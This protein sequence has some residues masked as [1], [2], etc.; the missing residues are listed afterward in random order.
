MPGL[1]Y[2][3]LNSRAIFSTVKM[4]VDLLMES[5]NRM[6]NVV[7]RFGWSFEDRTAGPCIWFHLADLGECP[8]LL[9]IAFKSLQEFNEKVGIIVTV[10]CLKAYALVR[11]ALPSRVIVLLMPL[12]NPVSAALFMRKWRPQVGIFMEAPFDTNLVLIAAQYNVRL[13]LL[14]AHIGPQDFLQWHS[15]RSSRKLLSN[16]LQCFSLV[17]PQSDLDM[18]YLRMFGASM[19]QMPGWS[20]ALS[21]VA[22]LGSNLWNHEVPAK[23]IL[24]QRKCLKG[25]KAW[26]AVNIDAGEEDILIR[27]HK[28]LCSQGQH[29]NLLTVIAP[30]DSHRCFELS[31]T[32]RRAGLSVEL[33]NATDVLLLD[34]PAQLGLFYH[35]CELVYYGGSMPSSCSPTAKSLS[36]MASAAVASCALLVGSTVATEELG[37]LICG[38]NGAAIHA[39]ED[40]AAAVQ[41][42]GQSLENSSAQPFSHVAGTNARAGVTGQQSDSS[43]HKS[44]NE[45]H[46]PVNHALQQAWEYCTW[47]NHGSRPSSAPN[48][49]ITAPW[50]ANSSTTTTPERT[51]MTSVGSVIDPYGVWSNSLSEDRGSRMCSLED[52]SPG[53]ASEARRP[54]TDLSEL[55]N[56]LSS[57]AGTQTSIADRVDEDYAVLHAQDSPDQSVCDSAYC[58]M[59]DA[60]ANVVTTWK[61]ETRESFGGWVVG[62]DNRLRNLRVSPAKRVDFC[63]F[64][65]SEGTQSNSL[66]SLSRGLST[67]LVAPQGTHSPPQGTSTTSTPGHTATFLVGS[68]GRVVCP[69]PAKSPSRFARSDSSGVNSPSRSAPAPAPGSEL[70]APVVASTQPP[71][72]AQ[73]QAELPRKNSPDAGSRKTP[74]APLLA[75]SDDDPTAH[76][77]E[78]PK[79]PDPAMETREIEAMQHGAEVSPPSQQIS[80]RTSSNDMDACEQTDHVIGSL[81]HYTLASSL[82]R[83]RPPGLPAKLP[84]AGKLTTAAPKPEPKADC[85]AVSSITLSPRRPVFANQDLARPALQDSPLVTEKPSWMC[86]N[87]NGDLQSGSSS[88]SPVSPDMDMGGSP[89]D[90]EPLPPGAGLISPCEQ[91]EHPV[92]TTMAQ[93]ATGPNLV[94][95]A[96]SPGGKNNTIDI[97]PRECTL[98]NFV[99]EGEELEERRNSS[100]APPS[101]TRSRDAQSWS[102]AMPCESLLPIATS[103]SS[104]LPGMSLS[105]DSSLKCEPISRQAIAPDSQLSHLSRMSSMDRGHYYDSAG[106]L[107][108]PETPR[109]GMVSMSPMA[110]NPEFDRPC[111][112]SNSPR[113]LVVETRALRRSLSHHAG[114]QAQPRHAAP[115]FS[116]HASPAR[117]QPVFSGGS[118]LGLNSALQQVEDVPETPRSCM[119][120]NSLFAVDTVFDRPCLSPDQTRSNPAKS[121]VPTRGWLPPASPRKDVDS[122][123]RWQLEQ[124]A[125]AATDRL[126][127]PNRYAL[128]PSPQKLKCVAPAPKPADSLGLL[129][130]LAPIATSPAHKRNTSQALRPVPNGSNKAS[131][132]DNSIPETSNIALM[133]LQQAEQKM[134]P[135]PVLKIRTLRPSPSVIPGDSPQISPLPVAPPIFPATLHHSPG[136]LDAPP[137]SPRRLIVSMS[138]PINTWE[139]ASGVCPDPVQQP[140]KTRFSFDLDTL[141][142]NGNTVTKSLSGP[143]YMAQVPSNLQTPSQPGSDQAPVQPRPYQMRPEKSGH[144]EIGTAMPPFPHRLSSRKSVSWGA[145]SFEHASSPSPCSQRA[146]SSHELR[147]TPSCNL[148]ARSDTGSDRGHSAD[149]SA[150]SPRRRANS[151]GNQ[152]QECNN[153]HRCPPFTQADSREI[154]A[155]VPKSPRRLSAAEHAATTDASSFGYASSQGSVV[156]RPQWSSADSGSL[157]RNRENATS[158]PKS[159]RRLSAAEHAA[160]TDASSFGYASREGSVVSR[161]QWTSVDGGSPGRNRENATSV[162]KSPRC[163]SAAEQAATTDASSFGYVSMEG[164]VVSRPQWTLV[165]GGSPGRCRE[166]A[167]TVPKS[168][169]RLSAAE[170]AATTDASSFKS[171][172][173]EGSVVSRVQWTPVEGGSTGRCVE[174]ATTVPKS[175]RRLSAAE[176]AATT[177]VSSFGSVSREG[178]VVSRVQWTPVDGGSPGKCVE[179]A[180]T[181]PKSPRRLSAFKHA[182]TTDASSF[183]SVSREGSVVSRLQWTS[184][185][186]GSPG[187]CLENATTVPK[188][189]RH[190]SA[191]ENA[192]T[193]DASSFG[194]VSREGSVVSR[195]QMTSVDGGS[196]GRSGPGEVQPLSPRRLSMDHIYSTLNPL[197]QSKNAQATPATFHSPHKEPTHLLP[198]PLMNPDAPQR[199]LQ[200]ILGSASGSSRLSPGGQS[201]T[202]SSTGSPIRRPTTA[203]ADGQSNAKPASLLKRNSSVQ[204]RRSSGSSNEGPVLVPLGKEADGNPTDTGALTGRREQVSQKDPQTLSEFVRHGLM[205]AAQE[206]QNGSKSAKMNSPPASQNS[207]SQPPPS[208]RKGGGISQPPVPQ[209]ISLPAKGAEDS[210]SPSS[211]PQS[212]ISLSNA[213]R[214]KNV[215]SPSKGPHRKLFGADSKNPAPVSAGPARL[216]DYPMPFVTKE[217]ALKPLFSVSAPAGAGTKVS[218]AASAGSST[219]DTLNLMSIQGAA[220]IPGL[221]RVPSPADALISCMSPALVVSSTKPAGEDDDETP[222]S[223]PKASAKTSLFSPSPQKVVAYPLAKA[224]EMEQLQG[225]LQKQVRPAA[226]AYDQQKQL[227]Q[228]GSA[229]AQAPASN[230]G[231][232]VPNSALMLLE[233]TM[234]PV[235]ALGATAAFNPIKTAVSGGLSDTKRMLLAMSTTTRVPPPAPAAPDPLT[236][237]LSTLPLVR[238]KKAHA[239]EVRVAPG[240]AAVRSVTN[241]GGP[242]AVPATASAAYT[243]AR[244]AA[245]P[246]QQA[247]VSAGY[248]SYAEL[249]SM[250]SPCPSAQGGIP[251]GPEHVAAGAVQNTL[252]LLKMPLF[253][254]HGSAH[255]QGGRKLQSLE[256]KMSSSVQSLSSDTKL[257]MASIHQELQNMKEEMKALMQTVISRPP[258]IYYVQS[259]ASWPAPTQATD[260][261]TLPD[262]ITP[263]S[264]F[265][266]S[267]PPPS[268]FDP[269]STSLNHSH[270][271]PQSHAPHRSQSHAPHGPQPHSSAESSPLA[272]EREASLTMFRSNPIPMPL[273][274]ESLSMAKSDPTP[275]IQRD[276]SFDLASP[277][278]TQPL[279]VPFYTSKET[280]GSLSYLLGASEPRKGKTEKPRQAS[281]RTAPP[282][283]NA[284]MESE[285]LP[286][287][288]VRDPSSSQ[289]LHSP[290]GGSSDSPKTDGEDGP[291][292]SSPWPPVGV[293]I[294]REVTLAQLGSNSA[295]LVSL[296]CLNTGNDSQPCLNT[297]DD[298]LP[299]LSPIG[300]CIGESTGVQFLDLPRPAEI[301]AFGSSSQQAPIGVPEPSPQ[302]AA[303]DS[304]HGPSRYRGECIVPAYQLPRG[305]CGP[306][307][308]VVT[309]EEELTL[310]VSKLL[311]DPI[312]RRSRGY[313]AAQGAAKLASSLVEN[314]WNVL[315]RTVITPSI[316]DLIKSSSKGG[317][318]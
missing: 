182:A 84:A 246:I 242:S 314:V 226:L 79:V 98:S 113:N 95:L 102:G 260:A 70:S 85:P 60:H 45:I 55:R 1:F 64:S 307:V 108:V 255:S 286:N 57:D 47:T 298:L 190:L 141:N 296:P 214:R 258:V 222:V 213:F 268:A 310:A 130:G 294:D 68:P 145:S 99:V 86:L 172:S 316:E 138:V 75:C 11:R 302:K 189:P 63:S 170:N 48:A 219:L 212:A 164:S 197:A 271:P 177:D 91:P 87:A 317:S 160:T 181:V 27:L 139:T 263:P 96:L 191:F 167:T 273:D 25:R 131:T 89:F 51:K 111:P 205:L 288:S 199:E 37:G 251:V 186:S 80:R 180:T 285:S 74:Q 94:Q 110:Q 254:Q 78:S 308:W 291:T 133:I 62:D 163:L 41:Q 142:L 100:N 126:S 24:D 146:A 18:A 228:I 135:S 185:D 237:F 223:S 289:G 174:N 49:G 227:E 28:Q 114:P 297:G 198:L 221:S 300:D 243:L 115:I 192:A 4:P 34:E 201:T 215:I 39:S 101:S 137:L 210:A 225:V 65:G 120:N 13:A 207:V 150:V 270:T 202:C 304:L 265:V 179:N 159:P 280:S 200:T 121:T 32:I 281:P 44:P 35:A 42:S 277:M 82:L 287:S 151:K 238:T 112:F 154:E 81:Q 224:Q 279:K 69:S 183:G 127:G 193:T 194:S 31:K 309:E 33:R 125:L 184:I 248:G 10:A 239:G 36:D 144:R 206:A 71:P 8:A 149:L 283:S 208:P 235:Q 12:D 269:T 52:G 6:P 76:L 22:A 196:P 117:R 234:K 253:P 118:T 249:A 275:S 92:P 195:L 157:G 17:V 229:Q 104:G 188:S 252:H 14:N 187:R 267:V 156:S 77:L 66:D 132:G 176:N 67:F 50:T 2:S 230:P 178:S 58:Q 153:A 216:G 106:A 232:E 97:T 123:S 40:A 19:Q 266:S 272:L 88:T 161:P 136:R 231:P 203:S 30:K 282:A 290:F 305:S 56:P 152:R 73:L 162:P 306:A 7:N 23:G 259:G 211:T 262:V 124:S 168:P 148:A 256:G 169:R 301:E 284:A 59:L 53:P 311:S 247:Q 9:P 303:G 21:H 299:C 90:R 61:R 315:D 155:T 16:V 278:G 26:L 245:C 134:P 293:M 217:L 165:D 5:R 15:N 204:A 119:T 250:S 261:S 72:L 292:Q 236:S 295:A 122:V 105:P 209:P 220:V 313:A 147:C 129:S 240:S 241:T 3:L 43:A 29:A 46:A 107:E 93:A 140:P 103:S 274:E 233:A 158:V 171:M 143:P 54:K 312:E 128:A 318:A 173:R 166:N 257:G 264:T 38:L 83:G 244:L 276:G 218:N 20:S 116:A 109:S 175:P